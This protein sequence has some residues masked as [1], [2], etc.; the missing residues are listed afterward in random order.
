MKMLGKAIHYGRQSERLKCDCTG[1]HLSLRRIANGFRARRH[2]NEMTLKGAVI[3]CLA[4]CLATTAPTRPQW[5][6]ACAHSRC[7]FTYFRYQR[8]SLYF[9]LVLLKTMLGCWIKHRLCT[10]ILVFRPPPNFPN[11]MATEIRPNYTVPRCTWRI[12]FVH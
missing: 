3:T 2:I 5:N 7:C 10:C 9:N 4:T 8:H 12:L 6:N 1:S 11:R